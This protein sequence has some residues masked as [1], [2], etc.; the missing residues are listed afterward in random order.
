MINP[1]AYHTILENAGLPISGV[2]VPH[3]G[4]PYVNGWAT[5]PA[6]E[7]EAQAATLLSAARIAEFTVSGNVVAITTTPAA[8][9]IELAYS[10][11]DLTEYE[12]ILLTNGAGTATPTS[13]VPI[14]VTVKARYPEIFGYAEATVAL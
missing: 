7:Q 5:P 2:S 1:F 14:T 13:D 8:A 12:V 10:H 9:S 4:A 6:P 3:V 11:G